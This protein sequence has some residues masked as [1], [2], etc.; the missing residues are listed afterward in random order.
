LAPRRGRGKRLT[1]DTLAKRKTSWSSDGSPG[2]AWNV[3][4]LQSVTIYGAHRGDMPLS[5]I[6]QRP[7][8]DLAIKF[9]HIA[10]ASLLAHALSILFLII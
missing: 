8:G 7:D 9:A 4:D 6:A 5:L 10:L 3:A 1:K 2:L